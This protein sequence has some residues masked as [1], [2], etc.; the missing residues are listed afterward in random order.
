MAQQIQLRYDTAANWTSNNPIL[1]IAE[2]GYETVTGNVKIGDGVTRWNVLSYKVFNIKGD[3]GDTGTGLS[4]TLTTT[5]DFT[6]TSGEL[7]YVEK[8]ITDAAIL[9]TS[10]IIIQITDPV[11]TLQNVQC[12]VVS[13]IE[14]VSYTIYATAPDGATG[15]ISINILIF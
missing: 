7:Q 14:G 3:K 5:I 11:F 12:G 1:G 10:V 8:T 9:S 2:V 6:T 13:I 15:I 4:R